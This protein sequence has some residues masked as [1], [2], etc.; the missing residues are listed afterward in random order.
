L[1]VW[2]GGHST[3]ESVLEGLPLPRVDFWNRGAT[4]FLFIPALPNLEFKEDNTSCCFFSSTH[5]PISSKTR[6]CTVEL[7][8]PKCFCWYTMLTQDIKCR[9]QNTWDSK[10]PEIAVLAVREVMIWVLQ[11]PE[12]ESSECLF[13]LG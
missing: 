5:P 1:V 13:V 3:R 6:F 7:K 12:A 2:R 4:R 11:Q 8:G 9:C 10:T